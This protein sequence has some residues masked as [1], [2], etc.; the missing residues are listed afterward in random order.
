VTVYR[1]KNSKFY[2]AQFTYKGKTYIKSTKTTNLTLA[3]RFET[4]LKNEVYKQEELGE[5][6]T[7]T[8]YEAFQRYAKLKRNTPSYK[9]IK[10]RIT[11][12]KKYFDDTNVD[13]IKQQ[14]IERFAYQRMSDG[15]SPNTT[16]LDLSALRGTFS[17]IE[18]LG[19]STPLIKEWPKMDVKNKR[20]RFLSIGEEKR[21]LEELDPNRM[22]SGGHSQ[23]VLQDNYDFVVLLLDTGV[24]YTEL[25]TLQIKDVDLDKRKIR[26]W[27]SKTS[28]ETVL[29]MTDRAYEILKRRYEDRVQD[30]YVFC[31]NDK[32]S[33]PRGYTVQSIRNAMRRAGL[34][35]CTI[36]TLRHTTCSRWAQSSMSLH[37]IAYLAGHSQIKTTAIYAHLIPNDVAK[38]A[39][40]VLNIINRKG[41]AMNTS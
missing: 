24:R 30:K 1:R 36:H 26:I 22:V 14:D 5:K 23:H 34:E 19:Y 37:E 28:S 40:E 11:I 10:H 27:R 6:P 17:H 39:V 33:K 35:D 2:F 31:R 12:L 38:K 29:H 9:T 7:I 4:K 3:K 8:L 20:V 16:R 32:P 13:T 41:S 18:R 25:A 21:L 15:A